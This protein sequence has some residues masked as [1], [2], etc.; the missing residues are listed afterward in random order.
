MCI[1]FLLGIVKVK[2]EL[3]DLI[4]P[5]NA[6]PL[7]P[8]PHLEETVFPESVQKFKVNVELDECIAPPY[9]FPELMLSAIL[10]DSVQKFKIN[11]EPDTD[12]APP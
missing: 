10:S 8:F 6:F 5:P 7:A 2:V 9:P 12:I 1:L 3:D 4:A 11:V